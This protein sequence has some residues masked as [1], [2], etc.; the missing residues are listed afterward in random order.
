MVDRQ[1]A[2][3]IDPQTDNR[4]ATL[5]FLAV[6]AA[7]RHNLEWRKAEAKLQA[8]LVQVTL[9]QQRNPEGTACVVIYDPLVGPPE[10]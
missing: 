6:L 4:Q 9:T 1:A 5:A 10:A 8:A 2:I 7:D 3:A